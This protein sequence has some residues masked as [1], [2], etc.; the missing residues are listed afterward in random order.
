MIYHLISGVRVTVTGQRQWSLA[1][2]RC[3]ACDQVVEVGDR[4][5]MPLAF[6]RDCASCGITSPERLLSV[7]ARRYHGP[8][9]EPRIYGGRFDNQGYYQRTQD[10]VN[11]ELRT[12]VAVKPSD[13][14]MERLAPFRGG[15]R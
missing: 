9:V 6:L 13:R 12:G 4:A 2:Y 15:N 1:D 11:F 7:P 8:V 10:E 14:K 5:P 3:S